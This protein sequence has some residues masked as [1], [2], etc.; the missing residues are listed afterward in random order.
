MLET[1]GVSV[2]FTDDGIAEIAKLSVQVNEQMENI[3]ARR[4][5]TLLER[6]LEEIS[7][8]ATDCADKKL[9]VDAAYVSQ[10][11]KDISG[12]EDLTRYIL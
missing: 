12:D 5:H 1:E 7:F 8:E 2:E 6:T 10:Q 3:G 11:L 4:L 9:V